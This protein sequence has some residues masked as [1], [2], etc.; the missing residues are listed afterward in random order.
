MTAPFAKTAITPVHGI[1]PFVV[2]QPGVVKDPVDHFVRSLWTFDFEADN[3]PDII[4]SMRR[5]GTIQSG[6]AQ[7]DT[8]ASGTPIGEVVFG[9]GADNPRRSRLSTR[10]LIQPDAFE[11][12]VPPTGGNGG[13]YDESIFIAIV[14]PVTG[15]V[16]PM[17][18]VYFKEGLGEG[19]ILP[20]PQIID[21][22]YEARAFE[23]GKDLTEQFPG[24]FW[25]QG[26]GAA[27]GAIPTSIASTVVPGLFIGDGSDGN[28]PEFLANG[29]TPLEQRAYIEKNPT[30]LFMGF[31]FGF[32]GTLEA[33]AVIIAASIAHSTAMVNG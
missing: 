21:L 32:P 3:F 5:V 8:P 25:Q 14:A 33:D 16:V 19:V 13:D 31:S 30:G 27:P 23:S 12:T 22:A 6:I 11:D 9:I 17:D 24:G 18:W 26:P 1:A 20:V 10:F 4:A 2:E 7:G 15:V 29:R 28:P